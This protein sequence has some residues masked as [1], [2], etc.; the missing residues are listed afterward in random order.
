MKGKIILI[1]IAATILTSAFIFAQTAKAAAPDLVVYGYTDKTYYTPG[2]TVT[3]KFWIYNRGDAT[4]ILKNVTIEYPWY[5][6]IWGGNKTIIIDANLSPNGN[7]SGT[8]TFEIPKDDRASGG[9]VKFRVYYEF[10][11]ST[12]YQTGSVSVDVV[13]GETYASLK[14]MDS[15]ITLFTIQVVLII[16]CTVIIAATVFLSARRPQVMWKAE[17][18]GE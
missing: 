1:L 11:G 13:T 12:T 18:K 17:E 5:N 3:S 4:A 8:D 16:V 7:Y 14:A 10:G 6:V 2:E 9:D 15:I